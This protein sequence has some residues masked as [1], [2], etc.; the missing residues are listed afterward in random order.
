MCAAK[1]S[2]QFSG[3]GKAEE[4]SCT[5]GDRGVGCGRGLGPGTLTQSFRGESVETDHGLGSRSLPT[6]AQRDAPRSQQKPEIPG[7]QSL[8]HTGQ[9]GSPG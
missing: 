7:E 8:R 2:P 6:W 5:K 1:F 4:S 3:G 9:G